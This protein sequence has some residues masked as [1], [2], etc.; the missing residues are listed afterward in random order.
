MFEAIPELN[1][2]LEDLQEVIE[3]DAKCLDIENVY[4]NNIKRYPQLERYS[5]VIGTN[6]NSK[7]YFN[8]NIDNLLHKKEFIDGKLTITTN[9]QWLDFS[10]II[11]LSKNKKF[12]PPV[13]DFTVSIDSNAMNF[14][15]RFYSMGQI[16]EFIN[17][18]IKHNIDMNFFPYILEDHINPYKKQYLKKYKENKVDYEKEQQT[19]EK[20]LRNFEI[21]NHI[22]IEHFKETEEVRFDIKYLYANGYKSF[23]EYFENKLFYFNNFFEKRDVEIIK[24]PHNTI[25]FDSKKKIEINYILNTFDLI[26]GYVLQIVIEKFKGKKNSL[27]D[28]IHN[29]L[30]NMFLNGQQLIQVL[31]FAYIYFTKESELEI[32][33]FF[34]FDK[35]WD[36]DK[37]IEK[38]YNIT[39]DIYL[40]SMNQD[41]LVRPLRTINGKPF[42]A[43]IGM[44]IFLTEDNKFFSSYIKLHS[45]QIVIIDEKENRAYQSAS[46]T[47]N[48]NKEFTDYIISF[49]NKYP[50]IDSLKVKRFKLHKSH[51]HRCSIFR[52]FKERMENELKNYLNDFQKKQ[53]RR[54]I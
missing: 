48:Q 13:I 1:Y 17:L 44:P 20:K 37:I 49:R 10:N 19:R 14:I 28:K 46:N 9:H 26:Y 41:F 54:K 53:D 23:E 18:K 38:A 6:D 40:Y 12:N 32:N 16:N 4:E 50:N 24:L 33:K 36:Y 51:N 35:S 7:Q 29:I 34:N 11:Y 15:D 45:V 30:K 3:N 31:H 8:L 25:F 39:W 43:D 42:I 27:E 52:L 5:L 47:V 22:D 2:L 21:I